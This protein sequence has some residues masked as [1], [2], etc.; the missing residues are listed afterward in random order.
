VTRLD[1]VDLDEVVR[2]HVEAFPGFFL[3]QLGSRFLREYYRSV[4]EYPNGILLVQR[5]DGT[6]AGFVAGFLDPASFYT[7]LR[8]RRA[9]LGIAALAGIAG[10]PGRLVTLLANYRRTGGAARQEIGRATA[11]LSSIAVRPSASGRGT[12]RTLVQRFVAAAGALGARWVTLTTDA[13]GNDAV[14]AFYL[15]LGFERVRA[16]EARPGR[17]LNEYRF[18]IRK[19]S[20]CE[21]RS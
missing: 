15:G 20:P 19:G 21:T 13:E 3:S 12:G 16:V 8:R 4:A 1:E 10:R 9:R 11:E 2:I 5:D 17:I 6:C 18:E 14:N 7:E